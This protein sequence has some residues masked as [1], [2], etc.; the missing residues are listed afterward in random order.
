[1][2][3][4][5]PPAPPGGYGYGRPYGGGSPPPGNNRKAIWSLVLGIVGILCCG[6]LGVGA[7]ILG[8]QAKKEIAG[9]GQAGAGLAQA[10]FILG[11]LAL[12]FTVVQV[13]LFAGGALSFPS[14]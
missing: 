9:T 8:N 14:T 12:V 4:E 3:Y 10:G 5:Q 6:P 2:S 13:I 7:I 11:I 1:M